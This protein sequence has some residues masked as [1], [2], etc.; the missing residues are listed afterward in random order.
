MMLF[1]VVLTIAICIKDAINDY[2]IEIISCIRSASRST[3]AKRLNDR[4]KRVIPGWTEYVEERHVLL[5]D[6][7]SLWALVGKPRQGYMYSQ[8][9]IARSRFKYALR[10]CLKNEKDLRAKALADKFA[11]NPRN[12]TTFWK[13]VRKLNS[14]P[15]LAQAVGGVSGESKI[16]DMW[17]NHFA[18]ILNSVNDKSLKDDVL[19]Q[20]DNIDTNTAAFSVQEVMNSINELSSGRSSGCDELNAEHFKFAG[21][22]CAATPITLFFN[23]DQS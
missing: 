15:P 8:L 10:F 23:D 21:I 5:G 22:P 7:Y 14:N 18:D 6:I 16:A 20:L 2:Y 13:E 9:G 3:V 12:I 19:N 17:K 1:T 11:N 4:N